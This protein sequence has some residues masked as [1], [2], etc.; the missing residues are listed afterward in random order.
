MAVEEVYF[1]ES[2]TKI[3]KGAFSVCSRLRKITVS[4]LTRTI[5]S[6]CFEVCGN[7]EDVFL[8][9]GLKEIR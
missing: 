7:L 5:G 8:S 2:V 9:D 4:A 3:G 6:Q 1:N